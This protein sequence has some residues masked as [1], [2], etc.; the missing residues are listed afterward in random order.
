MF[1]VDKAHELII[2]TFPA[3]RLVIEVTNIRH[4]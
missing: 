4:L 3:L 2:G 1:I